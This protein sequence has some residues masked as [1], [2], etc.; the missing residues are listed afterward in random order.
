[1]I[2]TVAGWRNTRLTLTRVR[3]MALD[4][5]TRAST[6]FSRK[7][8]EMKRGGAKFFS[9]HQVW[10]GMEAIGARAYGA[11]VWRQLPVRI[12]RSPPRSSESKSESEFSV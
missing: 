3:V 11:V 5:H 2:M 4:P 7:E 8:G 10:N 12:R 9:H 6:S 1:M